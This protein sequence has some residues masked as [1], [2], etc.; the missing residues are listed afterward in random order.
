MI[1]TRSFFLRIVRSFGNTECIDLSKETEDT[2]ACWRIDWL[3]TA[4]FT[5][6]IASLNRIRQTA[7]LRERERV[8]FCRKVPRKND[9][10]QALLSRG[11][12][13]RPGEKT[14]RER[15]ERERERERELG[16]R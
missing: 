15:K 7:Y 14:E 5:P 3:M 9:G 11:S 12:I 8:K 6:A 13:V 4:N 16:S 2:F 10:E 1:L